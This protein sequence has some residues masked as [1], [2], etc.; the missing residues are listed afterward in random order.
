MNLLKFRIV[1][2]NIYFDLDF[3]Y[4]NFLIGIHS[5]LENL[6]RFR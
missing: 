6:T 2:L 3:L 4:L 1:F 5:I